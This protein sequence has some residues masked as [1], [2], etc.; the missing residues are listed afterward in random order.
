MKTDERSRPGT[1]P[2]LVGTER[3]RPSS[4]TSTESSRHSHHQ[5]QTELPRCC[6]HASR[7]T[8]YTGSRRPPER[9]CTTPRDS[10]AG[11][12]RTSPRRKRRRG[13]KAP[14]RSHHLRCSNHAMSTRAH[15]IH[16]SMYTERQKL[17]GS[18]E[19]DLAAMGKE[20]RPHP[21]Y[22]TA[23]PPPPPCRRRRGALL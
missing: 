9:R 20:L 23:P 3:R 5:P 10:T 2:V 22:S 16:G 18:V 8:R 11:P 7:S 1:H 15:Q 21:L 6:T 13:T 19:E 17:D 4:T 14:E 12:E